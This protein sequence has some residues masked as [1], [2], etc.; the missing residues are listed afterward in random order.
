MTVV[1]GYSPA[2]GDPSPLHLAATLARSA[3]DDLLVV[4]VVPAAWPTPVARGADRDYE[5]W[6]REEGARSASAAGEVLAGLCPDVS[7]SVLATPG[8]SEA[9]TL[10]EQ[11]ERVDA[12][13]IVV[14]SRAEA[15]DDPGGTIVVSSTGDRLLH[16]S[17]VPVA[18]APRGFR[19]A[20]DARV[21]RATCAFRGDE[22]ST[23]VLE[24][25]AAICREVGAALRVVT[26]G[27]RGRT[28]YPPEVVGETE[29]LS[30]Y[31]EQASARQRDAV[32]ALVGFEPG[33]VETAVATGPTWPSALAGVTWERS[34][35]LVV[36]S[37]AASMVSRLFLGSTATR[38]IRAS[39]VPAVVVP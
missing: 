27:V 34:D 2:K 6:T 30:A 20:P 5:A 16:S 7:S 33:E 35:V 36:G 10:I 3:R 37:S 13:L 15:P 25:T 32:D 24:R 31:V 23:S 39:P 38:I 29:V 22:A 9:A 19:A 4:V 17:P 8:K 12:S 11:A 28:M 18:I 26:F 1:V 14:G 21:T